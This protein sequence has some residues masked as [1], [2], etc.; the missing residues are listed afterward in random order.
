[1]R[2]WIYFSVKERKMGER[3]QFGGNST[4]EIYIKERKEE[5]CARSHNDTHKR[6]RDAPAARAIERLRCVSPA[7]TCWGEKK[8]RKRE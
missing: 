4:R 7:S 1:L 2:L 3:Q 8:R 6:Q 5:I